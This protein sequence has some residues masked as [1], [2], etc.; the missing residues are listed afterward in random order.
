MYGDEIESEEPTD[1]S[2]KIV[3]ALIKE[4]KKPNKKRKI[5][6][7]EESQPISDLEESDDGEKPVNKKR[8][9]K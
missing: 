6:S 9:K 3:R 4:T 1:A 5:S 2:S 7:L 8:K